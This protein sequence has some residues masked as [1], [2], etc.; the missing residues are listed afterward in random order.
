MVDRGYEMSCFIRFRKNRSSET[1]GRILERQYGK[2]LG[3]IPDIKDTCQVI[4]RI[5]LLG[6]EAT[7]PVTKTVE[8]DCFL[9]ICGPNLRPVDREDEKYIGTLVKERVQ[10][11]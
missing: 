4:R 11:F 6:T 9:N 1:V 3:E 8:R 7:S 2:L 10:G 5:R